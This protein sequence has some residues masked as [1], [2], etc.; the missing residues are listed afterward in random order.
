MSIAV[1]ID[2]DN[3]EDGL[4]SIKLAGPDVTGTEVDLPFR[5]LYR[6]LG[7]PGA[8]ALDLLMVAGAC[9]VIDKSV[10]R[11]SAP[12]AWTRNLEVSFPVS[13]PKRWKNVSPAL[14]TA[15]TFLSG[16][17]W[18]TSFRAKESELF[19]A[20]KLRKKKQAVLPGQPTEFRA[21][22]LFSGGLDSL[23]G[24]IDYLE[25]HPNKNLILMGH[26]DTSGPRSQQIT[27]HE[28]LRVK[29]PNRT[30]LIQVR[31]AKRPA[32][33]EEPSLRSRSVVFLAL[34]LY[35]AIESGG[36]IPLLAPEN[37]LIALNLPL[38]LSRVGSCSTRTMHP[39]YLNRFREV[40]A[41]LG[42]E[43]KITNPLELKT[44]ADCASECL[45]GDLLKT[46]GPYTVSCAHGARRQKWVRKK[47]VGNCG[48]CVPCLFRRAS[49]HA[50]GCDA[51]LEYG[52]DV[53][54]DELTVSSPLD[55][56]DD[57]RALTSCIRTN[58]TVPE[59]RKAITAVASVE[60]L[61]AYTA[62]VKRGHDQIRTWMKDKGSK[63]LRQAAGITN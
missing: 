10:L 52:I 41:G 2:G 3:R 55:S 21:V 28:K 48:Y 29:Y 58:R 7:S 15:L 42:I 49:F 20:P 53:C 60:P 23:I 24:S 30:K 35:G 16:D 1:E 62:M 54:A 17:V 50:L 37:G 39:F 12:D 40:V 6:S 51:G 19:I 25:K 11:R 61:D 38:T 45:N 13:D 46:M 44:K 32:K 4:A 18:K 47:G 43:N 63:S 56:A 14:D 26:Y 34:G 5:E 27:L 57:I 59:I 8:M 36:E 22:T 33:N 31:V 9:Y